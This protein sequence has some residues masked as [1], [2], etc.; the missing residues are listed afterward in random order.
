MGASRWQQRLSSLCVMLVAPFV[1]GACMDSELTGCA[2]DR[3]G[4]CCGRELG[5]E[6]ICVA[7]EWRCQDADW[8]STA[9]CQQPGFCLTVPVRY[10][11]PPADKGCCCRE[12]EL[13][14][15]YCDGHQWHCNGGVALTQALC[16]VADPCSTVTE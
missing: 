4:C 2:E 16:E 13:L 14:Q 5:I 3:R 8:H 15:P 11:C 10:R 6:P 9:A 1:M 12:G 7:G